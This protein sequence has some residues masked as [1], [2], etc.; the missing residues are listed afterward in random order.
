MRDILYHHGDDTVVGVAKLVARAVRDLHIV[1]EPAD[2]RPGVT[3]DAA[4]EV[5][6]AA[7]IVDCLAWH[8][9]RGTVLGLERHLD[10]QVESG[11]KP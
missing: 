6:R 7:H 4:L 11:V 2:G 3:F 8:G 9:D 1:L 5:L 10:T